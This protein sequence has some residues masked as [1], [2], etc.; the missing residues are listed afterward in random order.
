LNARFG[1][2]HAIRATYTLPL[3]PYLFFTGMACFGPRVCIHS[4]TVTQVSCSLT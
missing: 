1:F 3:L 4:A 2:D